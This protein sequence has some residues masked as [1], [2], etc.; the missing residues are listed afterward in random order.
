MDSEFH[1]LSPTVPKVDYVFCDNLLTKSLQ[2]LRLTLQCHQPKASHQKL[3]KLSNPEICDYE[4]MSE[5]AGCCLLTPVVKALDSLVSIREMSAKDLMTTRQTRT[6][7]SKKH[8]MEFL[9]SAVTHRSEF[10][11]KISFSFF[12]LDKC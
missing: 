11:I 4:T 12:Q 3:P 9:T 7:E 1:L 2:D 8:F 10:I 5:I 6:S